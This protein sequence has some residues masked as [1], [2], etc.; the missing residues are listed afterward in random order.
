MEFLEHILNPEHHTLQTC[1]KV[2]ASSIPGMWNC[3]FTGCQLLNRCGDGFRDETFYGR[4][5]TSPLQ[6]NRSE[7]LDLTNH[8][9][10]S[11]AKFCTNITETDHALK[12]V[13]L[14]SDQDDGAFRLEFEDTKPI[15]S[16]TNAHVSSTS[17]VNTA[18]S[19]E[20]QDCER[21]SESSW[22]QRNSEKKTRFH[23]MKTDPHSC[24][25]ELLSEETS[26]F[27]VSN[28]CTYLLLRV[29]FFTK[30]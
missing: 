18:A 1:E 26:T 13:I 29:L 28:C 10:N 20:I 23:E 27:L 2:S 6:Q 17:P 22:N 21:F 4:H 15:V 16:L 19:V 30:T 8:Y 3:D 24:I 5:D 14:T 12:Q 25:D 11:L 9:T 7:S